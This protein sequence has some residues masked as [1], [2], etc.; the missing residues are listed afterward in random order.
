MR[1]LIGES[2][3]APRRDDD[4]ARCGGEPHTRGRLDEFAVRD[5]PAGLDVDAITQ[6]INFDPPRTGEDYVHRVGRNRPRRRQRNRRHVR[7]G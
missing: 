7:A 1:E 4:A 2:R 6:V 3:G 5:L